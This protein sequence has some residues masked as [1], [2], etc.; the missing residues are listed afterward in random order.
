MQAITDA[1]NAKNPAYTVN[2]RPM[3]ADDLYLKLPLATQSQTD[4]PDIAIN[5]V[6]RLALHGANG[7]I[8]DV[9]PL[10]A[11][12]KI[13]K[14]NYN[15]TLWAASDVGG[16]HYGVPLDMTALILFV[17]MDLYAKY[18]KGALD[19][20]VVTWDE[21]KAAGPAAVAD[22][23]IPVSFGWLRA[24]YLSQYGQ[25]GGTMTRDG[26]APLMSDANSR[27]VLQTWTELQK[28]GFIQNEGDDTNSLFS[29]GKLLYMLEGSWMLNAINESGINYKLVDFPV[30]SDTKAKGHWASSHQFTLPRNNKRSAEKTAAA[31]DFINFVGENSMMWAEAGQIPAWAAIT[32][33]PKFD[34]LPQAFVAKSDPS[35]L[36]VYT[37]QY[38]GYAVEAL[39]KV[40][41][42]IIFGRMAIDAGL[43]QA[44]QETADRIKAGG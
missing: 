37:Y 11:G 23:V 21:I 33:D 13:N 20:G 40:L 28:A 32:K 24:D 16:K 26:T 2:H 42:E 19:D 39:D 5:H 27:K 9:T 17:N 38:Y 25:L 43:K 14:A 18:G 41:G 15:P 31:L 10:L 7:Y 1:Y 34:R 22:G 30:Y 12:S 36:K 35:V 8:E 3:S 44:D 4:V 29:A 6:E